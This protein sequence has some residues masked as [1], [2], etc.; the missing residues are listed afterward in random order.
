MSNNVETDKIDGKVYYLTG[1]S[2][3][4]NVEDTSD[5]VPPQEDKNSWTAFW[6]R[7]TKR[8]RPPKCPAC[9]ADLD[10][11]NTD[12]A[13]IRMSNEAEDEWAWITPLCSSCNNWNNR[14]RMTLDKDTRIVR[15][16]MSKKRN[17]AMQKGSRTKNA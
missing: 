7:K 15:V 9:G 8:N 4:W 14:L 12:G 2:Y 3:A 13:H 10:D 16:K 1:N 5:E 6:I 17:T 11:S